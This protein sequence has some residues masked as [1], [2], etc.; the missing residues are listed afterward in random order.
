MTI[1]SVLVVCCDQGN[2]LLELLR[3]HGVL[4]SRA[5]TPEEAVRSSP[6]G[7]GVMI[8]AQGYPAGPTSLAPELFHE[9]RSRALRLYVEYPAAL[10][11]LEVG[12]PRTH[13]RGQYG[14]NLDREVISSDAFGFALR[15]SRIVLV[16]GCHFVPVRVDPERWHMAAARV[17]GCDIAVFGLPKEDVWPILFEH[18][19]G[20]M[21]VATT[22][23]SHF[24]TGRYA[25]SDAWPAILSMI[26]RWVVPD[27]PIPELT[28]AATVRPTHGRA[29]RLPAGAQRIAM[30]RGVRWFGNSGL[31]I[32]PSGK[33]GFREGFSS[34]EMYQDGRQAVSTQVRADCHGEVSMTLALGGRILG[35]AELTR[36]AANLNDAIYFFSPS[37]RGPRMDPKSPSYGLIGGDMKPGQS[38]VPFDLVTVAGAEK[39]D[40]AGVYYGDDF[41]RHLLGS[42]ASAAILGR[43]DWDER[44][45][46]EVLANFRTTGPWGFRTARLEEPEIQKHGWRHLWEESEGRWG[47]HMGPCVPHYQAY[48]W[49]VYLWLYHKTGFAPLLART[50]RG[51]RNMMDAFPDGWGSEGN[52]HETERCRM[53]LPLAWLLRVDDTPEHREWLRGIVEYVLA[54]QHASGAIRHRF[55]EETTTNEQYGTGECALIQ[56]NSDSVAD[57][58]YATNFAFLGLHEAAAATGDPETAQAADRLADFMIRIQIRSETHPELDGGWYRGFDFKRWDYWGSDGDIGWG[59]WA[60]ETGWTVGWISSTLAMRE[61]GTCLWDLTAASTI[62]RHLARLQPVMLPDDA[63]S[64]P[65][66][67][68]R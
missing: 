50:E 52:R 64:V 57:L 39:L 53:L 6:R 31:F 33:E 21:L 68:L 3:Q 30:E 42:A 26:V 15:K 5:T 40:G 59:V 17:S 27:S 63:L 8:L 51:I 14:S 7:S 37:A 19:A 13:K 9:A 62:G 38:E 20:G 48:P 56:S 41:A 25:P 28:Y 36:V 61:L 10:P 55:I 44:M 2:D 1:G 47:K 45:L 32:E 54:A 43:D 66:R 12:A 11:D 24:L 60:I 23:L 34:K 29:A 49:S 16:H 58:L 22:Q 35:D 65:L 18:P 4:F 46:L 67:S